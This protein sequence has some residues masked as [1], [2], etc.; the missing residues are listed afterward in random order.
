MSAD[1]DAQARALAT[2]DRIKTVS[3]L[4]LDFDSA[5]ADDLQA[6]L[7]DIMSILKWSI[8]DD[9]EET[10]QKLGYNYETP[11]GYPYCGCSDCVSRETLYFVAAVVTQGVA[12]GKIWIDS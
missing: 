5:W 10:I 7:E 1:L 11:S 9:G 8:E 3:G 2:I 6:D 12:D 4:K